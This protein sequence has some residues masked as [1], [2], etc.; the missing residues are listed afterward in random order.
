MV[1]LISCN[2]EIRDGTVGW[3]GDWKYEEDALG[4]FQKML[5]DMKGSKEVNRL[6]LLWSFQKF[7]M[8]EFNLTELMLP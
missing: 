1:N 2:C 3:D 6:R 7:Y 5:Y 8:S 4:L